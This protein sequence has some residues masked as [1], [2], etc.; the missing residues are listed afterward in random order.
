MEK[1][2]VKKP[3]TILVAVIIVIALGGVSLTHLSVDLLPEF[4]LPYLIVITAYPGASPEK[5]EEQV[6]KPIEN[7]LGTV[8][9]VENVSSTSSENYSIVQLEFA[10]GTDM[11][12]AMV[13]ISSAI[14]ELES[15]LPT[16]VMKPNIMEISLDM[17]PT[18]YVAVEREGYD[19]YELTDFVNND[20]VP[21]LSRQEGVASISTIGLVEKSIQVELNQ[22][23]IDEL[24]DRILK[25]IDAS[26]SEAQE[27]IDE[28][29]EALD[30]AQSDLEDAQSNF[31]SMVSSAI[32]SQIDDQ[33]AVVAENLKSGINTLSVSLNQL[34]DI[35]D[36]MEKSQDKTLDEAK[37]GLA[38]R[39]M[40][41]FNDF[42]LLIDDAMWMCGCHLSRV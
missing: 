14:N 25:E 28:A 8:S 33:S 19:I 31:G 18:M 9:G 6:S 2:S 29:A 21:Y 5:I 4:S 40:V 41:S 38:R 30:K 39:H 32:F 22:E 27:T 17:L 35:L 20:V 36:E 26:L 7:A 15:S 23:K 42:P 16:G 10:D 3:Y 24:N 34:S 12:V 13:R 37:Y 1:L 11:N